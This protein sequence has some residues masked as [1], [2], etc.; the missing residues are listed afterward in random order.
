MTADQHTRT[1]AFKPPQPATERLGHHT[2]EKGSRPRDRRY[3]GPTIAMARLF[4]PVKIGPLE[5]KNRLIM[6]AATTFY[7]FEESDRDV[8]FLAARAKGG[9]S[10]LVIGALQV[11]YP[12]K[13]A[14]IGKVNIYD[15]A[16][17]PR[18][19][20]RTSVIHANGARAA[21]Q[22]AVYGYWS[23]LGT[24]GTAEDVAPSEVE[25]PTTG[26]H[27]AFER[28]E[29][30]PRSRAL[31][32]DEIQ[33]ILASVGDA[34]ARARNANF[35]A[36]ELQAVGGN[37]F[38]RFINP[39]TNRRTDQYGGSL[40]NRT[41][42]LLE[43]VAVIKGRV[44]ADFPLICRI[45]GDDMLPWGVGIETWR[46]VAKLLEKAGVHA[47]SIYPGWH[48]TRAPRQQMSVPRGYF[49]D[50]AAD[51]KQAVGI[52][53]VANMRINDPLLAAQIIADGKA[54]LVAMA[55]PLIADPDLPNKAREGRLDDIRMCT[56]C[57]KCWD[58]L[59]QEVPV[60]CSVNAQAGMEAERRIE[61]VSIPKRVLVIGAGPGGMEAARVAAL[62]GHQVTLL[63][64]AAV[65][66]GQLRQV[67]AGL[68]KDEWNNLTE[69]LTKQIE[70]LGIDVR[71][72]QEATVEVVLA[73]RPDVVIVATGSEP[74]VPEI[75]GSTG[76]NVMTAGDVLTGAR[77]VGEKVVIVG[78]G[79]TACE[80]GEYLEEKGKSVTILEMQ[81][82]IGAD[83]GPKNRWVIIDRMVKARVRME[84]GA[85]VAEITE[86]GVRIVRK[87]KYRE[88]FEADTVV[89]AV[90]MRAVDS[91]AW[92]LE[93]KV[94]LVI[95]VG[96]CVRPGDIRNAI[97]G[98]FLAGNGI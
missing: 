77:L 23:K 76:D 72:N 80:V 14:D 20:K 40:E 8:N 43:A 26:L 31:G 27:P 42:L 64:K 97:E 5:L 66:G 96:D 92:E 67:V 73:Q 54:D 53:V 52:P 32:Q 70:K 28:A 75:P 68:H 1:D 94:P 25:I 24:A 78:G 81:S 47:L 51:I 74:L 50:L 2:V 88:F 65:L 55:T 21:A 71:L 87:G 83:I 57:L 85:T 62:R 56:A 34:A 30:L 90:G 37:L 48:E 9:V 45:P 98:G 22:L 41:R 69:F 95:S 7:D 61:P 38:C 13:R 4:E 58:D 19:R 79:A 36:I 6:P 39:F 82:A 46:E 93:G 63:E 91:L 10:L 60:R 49:V 86:K 18:L 17:V 84:A 29:F 16:D 89:V 33:L 11:L 3:P 35:D 44:G 59:I 12:G 15:D